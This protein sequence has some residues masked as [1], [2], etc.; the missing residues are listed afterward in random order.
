MSSFLG[1]IGGR[2]F[3]VALLGLVGVVVAALTGLDIEP[4]K[5]TVMGILGSFLIGQGLADGL[6]GGKTSS[7]PPKE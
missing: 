4:Y 6:S 1:K 5:E 3:V 7:T 2:K